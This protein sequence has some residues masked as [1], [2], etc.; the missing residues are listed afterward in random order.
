[1]MPAVA[2]A[3]S[4]ACIGGGTAV[5]P[6]QTTIDGTESGSFD[7]RQGLAHGQGSFQGTS[8]DTITGARAQ[9]YADQV[10]VELNGSTGRIRLPRVV[11]PVLHGGAG[12]WFELKDLQITDRIIEASAAVN[13]VNHPKVHIDRVTGSISIAGRQ[14]TFVGTCEAVD[15]NAQRKF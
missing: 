12:G 1:M 2:L 3:L 7:Y 10:D 14:G 6:E 9:G 5:K 4:L 15:P 13:F 11:L 8:T